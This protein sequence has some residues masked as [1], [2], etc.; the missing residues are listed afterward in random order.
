MPDSRSTLIAYDGPLRGMAGT[1]IAQRF[2][3]S[4]PDGEP[5]DVYIV[6]FDDGRVAIA[7][8]DELDPDHRM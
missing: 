8:A 4:S 3:D 2:V 6:Q 1:V 7:T 5:V